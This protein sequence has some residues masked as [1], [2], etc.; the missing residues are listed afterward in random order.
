MD[1]KEEIKG[2][3]TYQNSTFEE[4][5]TYINIF[6][7]SEKGNPFFVKKEFRPYFFIKKRD[8]ENASKLIK[9]DIEETEFL[10]FEENSVSKV[11][12]NSS[13]DKRK[14]GEILKKENI[15]VYEFDL[16]PEEQFFNDNLIYSDAKITGKKDILDI[17]FNPEI[18]PIKQTEVKLKVISLDIETNWKEE[19]LCISYFGDDIKESIIV[20]DEKVNGAKSFKTEK[21]ML[22]Y[23]IDIIKKTDPDIITGWNVID[24][25]LNII[26]TRCRKYK[27]K[28]DL[29][30]TQEECKINVFS[31]FMRDSTA[32]FFGRVVL[33]GM[34]VLRMNFVNVEDYTL[35]TAAKTILS[36]K[37]IEI[38]NDN[39]KRDKRD[40]IEELYQKEKNKLVEYN[41]V[42]AKLVYDILMKDQLSLLI[43]RSRITGMRI[44]KVKQSIKSLDSMY[45]KSAHKR[46]VVCYSMFSY[47]K[48]EPVVG[49]Y[50]MKS[51]PGIYENLIVLD[52]KSLYPSI[53]RTYNI[54]PFTMK[55]NG[56]IITANNVHFDDKQGILPEILEM[57]WKQRDETKKRKDKIGSYAFKVTMNAFYGAIANPTCRFFSMD[58]ANAITSTAR[59]TIKE[60]I[61]II[62][63]WN[64]E[65]IYSDTDSIFINT[66]C[67]K[68]ED[69]KKIGKKIEKDINI[70]FNEKIKKNLGVNSCIELQFEK[71][72]EKFLM[73]SIRDSKE[74]AKKRYAG[75]LTDDEKRKIDITGL[76]YVRRDWTALAKEFQ[77]HLLEI[78][79]FES[80]NEKIKEKMK[81]YIKDYADKLK[82]GDFDEK[83]IY[84]KSLNKSV[85]EY[86]KT[87][88]PHVKAA[89]KMESISSNIIK[90]VMTTDGPEPVLDIK[91]Q[92]DYE[93]YAKK[94]L[95]PIADSILEFFGLSFDEIT[96]KSKQK[97]L[98]GF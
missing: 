69:A 70:I 35:N 29:G 80:D 55:K 91:H 67:E 25:D 5:K 49:A 28:F 36:D 23:F 46:K 54:D 64:Y 18:E 98:F 8:A 31:D 3:I 32:N 27:I 45:I 78:L 33:D 26:K 81:E 86:T 62:E 42:D 34:S 6:G 76:E 59:A 65:V 61:S 15:S 51:K 63:S 79:F 84:K 21:E 85:E 7:R 53:M 24:F 82:C 22:E 30:R 48:E 37:K 77:Y 94:Q 89:K 93:H 17:F 16:D 14:V 43:E 90:Y 96:A 72:Y 4:G 58:I 95:K 19:I 75:L 66:K 13:D 87:T 20:C 97:K 60:T 2:F 50:V 38:M 57:L 11:I 71:T 41:L 47:N 56:K 10:D 9:L 92:I 52:F 73:P 68:K 12:F 39:E 83:L 1:K 44:D 88:P 74:G 40:I